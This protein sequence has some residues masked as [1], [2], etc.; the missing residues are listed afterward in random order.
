M[1]QLIQKCAGVAQT[2]QGQELPQCPWIKSLL[3]II[4][5]RANTASRILLKKEC[6]ITRDKLMPS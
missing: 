3:S 1:L 6:E 5:I 2:G 4:S